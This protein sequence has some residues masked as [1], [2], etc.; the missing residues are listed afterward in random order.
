LKTLLIND[1]MPGLVNALPDTYR[2]LASSRIVVH[3]SVRKITLHGSCGPAGGYRDD[4]DIDLCLV[5][6]ICCTA[7]EDETTGSLLKEVLRTSLDNSECSVD[8]DLAAVFDRKN[9]G[10]TCF[11]VNDYPHLKCSKS[12]TGCIGI[13]KIQK[14]FTGFVPPI[15]DVKAMYPLLTIWERP[16]LS[17]P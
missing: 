16:F 13:Y 12:A 17:T 4:S 6:D 8:L 9:C 7:P 3:P 10:L 14:C 1:F 11:D 15:T 5:T 2:L